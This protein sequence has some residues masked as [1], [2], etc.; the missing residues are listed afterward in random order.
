MKPHFN[1]L[2]VDL[3]LNLHQI[4]HS[5]ITAPFWGLILFIKIY[6]LFRKLT[7]LKKRDTQ[8]LDL[9][10]RLEEPH[11]NWKGSFLAHVPSFHVSWKSVK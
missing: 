3:Y 4:A 11:Q 8:F 7:M 5:Q 2:D 6:E 9:P 1:S 10:L